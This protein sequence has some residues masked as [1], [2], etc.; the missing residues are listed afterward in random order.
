M[1]WWDQMPCPVILKINRAVNFL[2]CEKI[3]CPQEDVQRQFRCRSSDSSSQLS[4]L[5]ITKT[6]S[7][8]SFN[9]LLKILPFLLNSFK[10][11]VGIG[12]KSAG[13]YYG[14]ECVNYVNIIV[15]RDRR[16]YF[17]FCPSSN[18]YIVWIKGPSLGRNSLRH[19]TLYLPSYFSSFQKICF[20]IP[21]LYI[22]YG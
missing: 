20:I 16:N 15:L 1:K 4:L 19:M 21:L 13:R 12:R 18:F 3:E 22:C 6:S 2:L 11:V 10:W 9:Y 7:D 14:I 5:F 17:L 8:V